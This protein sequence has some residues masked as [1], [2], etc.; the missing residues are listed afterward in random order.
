MRTFMLSVP[1][2]YDARTL[3]KLTAA[4]LA[5]AGATLPERAYAV[6]LGFGESLGCLAMGRR[7]ESWLLYVDESGDFA[8]DEATSVVAG[9]LLRGEA[10][11][12]GS[13]ALRSELERIFPL[14]PWPPHTSVLNQPASRAY[15]ALQ[16][17]GTPGPGRDAACAA[18]APAVDAIVA[19]TQE[20]AIA[21][22]GA[23]RRQEKPRFEHLV[24]VGEILRNEAPRASWALQSL[25]E[26]ERGELQAFLAHAAES[27]VP[28]NAVVIAAVARATEADA[29]AATGDVIRDTYVDALETLL[30]RTVALLRDERRSPGTDTRVWA[31]VATRSVGILGYG[32]M[33]LD[34]RH[35]VEVARNASSKLPRAPYHAE[36][37]IVSREFVTR[38]DETVNPGLVLAD[39][40][41]NSL[42][43]SLPTSASDRTTW[44]ALAAS[45]QHHVKLPLA[46]P[47][48]TLGPEPLPTIA[49]AGYSREAILA[50]LRGEV[51]TA[52]HEE[53]ALWAREQAERWISSAKRARGMR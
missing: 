29:G 10:T 26:A 12:E 51:P 46:R 50:A 28:E 21:F 22:C 23:A 19:S 13:R 48:P 47:A 6:A 8:R 1:R 31:S 39:Y 16:G 45:S 41:A 14:S 5:P 34:A 38:Y 7:T 44:A 11:V 24:A 35:V 32:L 30:E 27:I 42:R 43:F 49:V 17:A 36:P 15:F 37:R 3:R 52:L 33:N 4:S 20:A 53:R 9:L 25:V 18:I 40:V 2:S